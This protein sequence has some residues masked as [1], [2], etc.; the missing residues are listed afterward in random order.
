[1]GDL[2]EFSCRGQVAPEWLF[3]N[4]ACMLGQVRR[5]ETLDDRLEERRRNSQIMRRSPRVTERLF[6][7]YECA[8]GLIV[9]THILEQRQKTFERLFVIDSTRAL[10]TVRHPIVQTRHPPIRKG[11]ADH[12]NFQGP[13]LYH[14]IECRKNHLVGQVARHT[15][16]H[17]R[18]RMLPRHK[19]PAPSLTSASTVSGLR[20]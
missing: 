14:C 18:I 12:W 1:M 11:N 15:E 17:Q 9:S 4:D 5:A 10:N 20:S 3:H 2:V 16:E 19:A 7:G 13:S 8:R 6:D